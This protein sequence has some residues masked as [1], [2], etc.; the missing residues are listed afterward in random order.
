MIKWQM[1]VL[2][3]MTF[4]TFLADSGTHSAVQPEDIPS[5]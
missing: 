3:Q 1:L 2:F 4:V 5:P